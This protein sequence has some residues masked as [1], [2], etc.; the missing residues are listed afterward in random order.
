MGWQE[1]GWQVGLGDTEGDGD[2]TLLPWG[3]AQKGHTNP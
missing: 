1:R 3:T 2:S